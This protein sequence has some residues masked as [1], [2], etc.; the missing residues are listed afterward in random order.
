MI[1]ARGEITGKKPAQ[2]AD[3]TRDPLTLAVTVKRAHEIT[4]L[5]LTS[6]WGLI[7]AG[8]LKTKRVS[9]INRTL[10]LYSSLQELLAPEPSENTT[11]PPP[12][13]NSRPAAGQGN[14]RRE[15]AARRRAKENNDVQFNVQ[16]RNAQ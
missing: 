5:G 8:R 14:A 12:I 4:G 15:L 16:R 1:E 9:G 7:K 3:E 2:T 11:V 10:I 6:L 13:R